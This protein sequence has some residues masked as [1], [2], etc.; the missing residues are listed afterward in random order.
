MKPVIVLSYKKDNE[1]AGSIGALRINYFLM[2]P[3][4][5]VPDAKGND[6]PGTIRPFKQI[7]F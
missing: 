3:A 6:S 7:V 1:H 5:A 2:K 4:M